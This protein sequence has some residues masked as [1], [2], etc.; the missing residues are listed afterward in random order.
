MCILIRR[1]Y[2]NMLCVIM[3]RARTF[4]NLLNFLFLKKLTKV[5]LSRF[6]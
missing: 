3:T 2:N 1:I 5:G 6:K 4:I